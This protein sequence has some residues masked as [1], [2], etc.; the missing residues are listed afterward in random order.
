MNTRH[1]NSDVLVP[2]DLDGASLAGARLEG[3]WLEGAR[4]GGADLRGATL[5]GHDV[6]DLRARGA[7]VD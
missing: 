2:V 4:L 1:S 7:L 6:A 5:D 3:A